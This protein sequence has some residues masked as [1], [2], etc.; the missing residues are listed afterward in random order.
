MVNRIQEDIKLQVVDR[1]QRVKKERN[2][3]EE[4]Q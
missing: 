4:V 1:P 3:E 2:A